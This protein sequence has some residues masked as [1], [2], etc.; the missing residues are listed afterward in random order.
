MALLRSYLFAPGNQ[1]KLLDRV[2]GCGADAVVLDLEDAVPSSEKATARRLVAATAASRPP[3]ATDGS[4]A[5]PRIFVRINAMGTS[6]WRADVDAVIGPGIQGLRVPKTESL[7]SLCR[8][9]DAISARERALGLP[10]GGIRLVATIESARGLN[11]AEALAAAPRLAGFTFG[12]ADYCADIGADPADPLTTLHACSR[13]VTASRGGRVAPPV[14]SV[15]TDLQDLEELRKDTERLK[16]L[17]FFGR[18]A[19]HPR[20]V[21]IINAVFEPTVAEVASARE[22][23]AAYDAAERGGSAV[24]RIGGAFV[25]LAVVRRARALLALSARAGGDLR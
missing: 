3:V 9:H 1:P 19:I 7:E 17:G 16:R 22:V 10:A 13:L 11:Q 4:S 18:S 6:D 15:F 2:F 5:G 8:L 24:T 12:A 21:G 23:V 25:D 20:Q 14:A